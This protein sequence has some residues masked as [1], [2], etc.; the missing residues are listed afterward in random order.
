MVWYND[1]GE[2]KTGLLGWLGDRTRPLDGRTDSFTP[3]SGRISAEWSNTASGANFPGVFKMTHERKCK[4]AAAF[5][6]DETWNH[7]EITVRKLDVIG[8]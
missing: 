6:C 5:L 3:R 1:D 8:N 4:V 7:K 2:W